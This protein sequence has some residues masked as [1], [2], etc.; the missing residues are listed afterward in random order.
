MAKADWHTEGLAVP[1]G[2]PFAEQEG[3]DTFRQLCAAVKR[4]AVIRGQGVECAIR[5]HKDACCCACPVKGSK[6]EL[7]KV[8]MRI[9][10]LS[11]RLVADGA[12]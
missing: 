2:D 3:P 10:R 7:C 4:E 9:E 8:G 5:D 11:T 12:S 6:G 1:T